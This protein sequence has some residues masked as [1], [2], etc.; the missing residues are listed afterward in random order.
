MKAELVLLNHSFVKKIMNDQNANMEAKLAE[1]RARKL[2]E[3]RQTR[4]I[5]QRLF[6]LLKRTVRKKTKTGDFL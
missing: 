5:G 3:Q 6:G 4:N 2:D 1:F